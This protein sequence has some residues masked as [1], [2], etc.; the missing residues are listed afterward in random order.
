M[1]TKKSAYAVHVQ[2]GKEGAKTQSRAKAKTLTRQNL[3]TV[4]LHVNHISRTTII[5]D[6]RKLLLNTL[7]F[8]HEEGCRLAVCS[9]EGRGAVR[10]RGGL[11]ERDYQGVISV[12]FP[13][14]RIYSQWITKIFAFPAATPGT[15]KKC[16]WFW[17]SAITG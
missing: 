6:K 17:A 9:W 7:S 12:R 8:G 4:P 13:K 2:H 15:P 3:G 11:H 14:V 16:T 5:G 1:Q 10:L